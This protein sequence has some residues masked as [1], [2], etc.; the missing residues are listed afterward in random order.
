MSQR[1]CT[2]SWNEVDDAETVEENCSFV[3]DLRDL[4]VVLLVAVT[5]AVF[6]HLQATD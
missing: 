4:M 2:L 6:L 3:Q 1:H 5:I